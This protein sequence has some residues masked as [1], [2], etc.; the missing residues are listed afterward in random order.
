MGQGLSRVTAVEIA[1]VALALVVLVVLFL[2]V[3]E[4][5][6]GGPSPPVIKH[7]KPGLY[8]IN[9]KLQT[10][11]WTTFADA[12]EACYMSSAGAAVAT[13]EDVALCTKP[14][15]AKPQSPAFVASGRT[16]EAVKRSNVPKHLWDSPLP[17]YVY[18]K[19]YPKG[20]E[21][22][23]DAIQLVRMQFSKA[24]NAPDAF[25]GVPRGATV[26][27]PGAMTLGPTSESVL[28]YKLRAGKTEN[29]TLVIA[30]GPMVGNVLFA[31]LV[32]SAKTPASG[33]LQHAYA[34]GGV[35]AENLATTLFTHDAKTGGIF[36]VHAG[37]RTKS[38][39]FI[40]G[41]LPVAVYT[42]FVVPKK[43]IKPGHVASTFVVL[44][45]VHS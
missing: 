1:G 23:K 14:S 40:D 27:L 13:A 26:T 24:G 9:G 12:I 22:A 7:I 39:L 42:P 32:P 2:L 28:L 31:A 25:L 34:P 29:F 16:V 30:D 43:V 19:V 38:P 36:A 21:D 45:P 4:T 35:P 44:K 37:G 10:E 6:G 18:L 5:E 11:P 17:E 41:T 8:Y 20:S 3:R 33:M 15:K